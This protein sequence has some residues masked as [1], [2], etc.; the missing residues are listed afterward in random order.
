MELLFLLLWGVLLLE[1]WE[2]SGQG[3]TVATEAFS[4]SHP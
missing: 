3:Y 1:E 4:S 2:P